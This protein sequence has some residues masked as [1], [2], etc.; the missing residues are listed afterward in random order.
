MVSNRVRAR[1][2]S[3]AVDGLGGEV[4]AALEKVER[5]EAPDHGG[6]PFAYALVGA[7]GGHQAGAL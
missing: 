4:A 3:R 6:E 7:A 2:G 5:V 1:Q